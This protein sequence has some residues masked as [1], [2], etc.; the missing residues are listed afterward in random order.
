MFFRFFYQLEVTLYLF[1]YGQK[2]F[3][4]TPPLFDNRVHYM[5]LA[6]RIKQ[7]ISFTIVLGLFG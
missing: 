2:G 7:L 3:F 1:P 5:H 4:L 6:V